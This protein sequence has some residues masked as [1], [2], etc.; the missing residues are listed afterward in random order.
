MAKNKEL[1]RNWELFFCYQQ[2][3]SVDNRLRAWRTHV[4]V[5][6][7]ERMNVTQGLLTIVHSSKKK[8]IFPLRNSIT[9]AHIL[10]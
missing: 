1:S 9:T 5:S 7:R 3:P 4:R 2:S 6:L 8:T 10:V